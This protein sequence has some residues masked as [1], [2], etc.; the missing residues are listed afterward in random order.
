VTSARRPTVLV[1]TPD[2]PPERGGIQL[3]TLRIVSLLERLTPTVVTLNH[4][5]AVAFDRDLSACVRRTSTSGPRSVT[6]AGLNAAAV[7]EAVAHRP[8]VV[9]SMH[10]VT[11]PAA[12]LLA[13]ALRIP[14]V[15]YVHGH[16]F[17]VKP[18]LAR[19]AVTAADRVI[20]VSRSTMQLAVGAGVDP[21]RISVVHPGVDLPT[22]TSAGRHRHAGP[23]GVLTISRLEE[24]YKGHD[25]MLRA[26][27]LVRAKVPDVRWRVV[28][29]GPLRPLLQER[30][31]T[32]G[33]ADAVQFLGTIS[34]DARDAEFGHAS[35]FCMVSR[36][37]AGAVA[38]EGFG[39]VYLE[40][41]AHGLPVVAGAVG[42]AM[43]A[44][45][46]D[47]TGLLVDPEDHPAVALALVRLLTEPALADRLGQGGRTQAERTTWASTATA[48]EG[49]LL[50][51]L[52]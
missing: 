33:L 23:P 43:D 2:F 49:E 45:L 41:G 7:R 37:Q 4:P 34:D 38:G 15:Q 52:R 28:G 6:I 44:V 36:R 21:G 26:L 22:T 14:F 27:P 48:V 18:R 20:A 29:D 17:G 12:A 19:F 39:I 9:L 8:A 47:E 31:V 1:L 50:R 32:S 25:V 42:G 24:S 40:A 13:R 3:T 5:E 11:S 30:S 35:V 10:M 51:V 46:E 16:E